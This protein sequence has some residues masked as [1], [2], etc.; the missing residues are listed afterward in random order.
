M[1]A[2]TGVALKVQ[3]VVVG[4]KE[5]L[6]NL[7]NPTTRLTPVTRHGRRST[8]HGLFSIKGYRPYSNSHP[9]RMGRV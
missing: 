8:Q 6:S 3:S 7:P 5:K 2:P 1:E 4:C 9:L